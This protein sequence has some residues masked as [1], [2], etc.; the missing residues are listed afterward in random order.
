[1]KFKNKKI[2]LATLSTCISIGGLTI[3]C[4]KTPNTIQSPVKTPDP[5]NQVQV[6]EYLFDNTNHTATITKFNNIN[7]QKNIIIPAFVSKDNIEYKVNKIAN[8]VFLNANLNSVVFSDTISQIGDFAFANNQLS[9]IILPK[10]LKVLGNNA[11]SNNPFALNTKIYLPSNTIWAKDR[12]NAAFNTNN[13]YSTIINGVKS[14][15]QNNQ[16]YNFNTQ[17]DAWTIQSYLPEVSDLATKKVNS[18]P[19]AWNN[20]ELRAYDQ[21]NYQALRFYNP[22]IAYDSYDVSTNSILFKHRKNNIGILT[23]NKQNQTIN[24]HPYSYKLKNKNH[25]TKFS[26]Y[27]PTK[28]SYT[29]INDLTNDSEFFDDSKTINYQIGDIISFDNLDLGDINL[30]VSSNFSDLNNISNL[31]QLYNLNLSNS[32]QT[33]GTI[34]FIITKYGLRPY[35]ELYNIQ[36]IVINDNKII[37]KGTTKA[38]SKVVVNYKNQEY[39]TTSDNLGKFSL[40]IAVANYDYKIVNDIVVKLENQKPITTHIVA[41]NFRD[42][43]FYIKW[44]N[45]S[46]EYKIKLAFN[47]FAKNLFAT[48]VDIPASFNTIHNK[49]NDNIPD[50]LGLINEQNQALKIEFLNSN[51]QVIS[52]SEINASMSISQ[53]NQQLA[54]INYTNAS[55]INITLESNHQSITATQGNNHIKLQP[56]NNKHNSYQIAINNGQLSSINNQNFNHSFDYGWKIQNGLMVT[57]EIYGKLQ[58]NGYAKDYNDIN[59]LM[60][61]VAN[62]ITKGLATD[63]QKA[64]AI[65][66]WVS[67]NVRY[68]YFGSFSNYQVSNEYVFKR[69]A[70]VCGNYAA[71]AAILMS[72]V[73]IV[74]RVVDG[75]ATT[76]ASKWNNFKS[77]GIDHAW[78]QFWSKDLATWI[79]FDPTWGITSNIGQIQPVFN[80]R[81]SKQFVIMVFWPKNT[82]YLDYFKGNQDQAF[83]M[84]NNIYAIY[85]G[86][87]S[88][89]PKLDGIANLAKLLNQAKD[90]KDGQYLE[91]N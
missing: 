36:P 67:Q 63:Y 68:T 87:Y 59:Q 43:N 17:N 45:G 31:N 76:P 55:Y 34:S 74:A 18:D 37:I 41:N 70:G 64:A 53:I 30:L 26:I 28:N 77:I 88:N 49:Y 54:N 12:I 81:R 33:Q 35:K 9:S 1:M 82:N 91:V 24:Y 90:L 25:F 16:V 44:S 46:K 50:Q 11:F 10:N 85:N 13:N 6:Y 83:Y 57:N 69:L 52:S 71:L 39:T 21:N 89:A 60:Q 47:D 42:S 14:I 23:F 62:E 72:Q 56:I 80:W 27:S 15:I 8:A 48:T 32:Y 78:M 20:R 2:L 5:N 73:G 75:Y 66:Q 61:Q 58:T 7:N 40:T 84:L 29:Y 4:S 86:Y 19:N 65:S 51:H 79:T 3:A 22:N 38:N